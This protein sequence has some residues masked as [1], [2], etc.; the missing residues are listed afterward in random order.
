M[1]KIL[2]A[3]DFSTRS[4]RAIRRAVILARSI[5]ASITLVHVV[6][7]DQPARMLEAE[8][9]A[10]L[11]LLA[12]HAVSI[13]EIEGVECDPSVV[14]GD[15]FEGI[16]Q[17]AAALRPDLLV[18]G[19]HRRQALRDIFAGTTAERAI[20]ASRRPVVMANAV[21]AA[22][23]RHVLVALDLSA[24]SDAVLR[25]VGDLD[26]GKQA[27]LSVIHVFDAPGSGPM[28]RAVM[29]AT[30]REAYLAEEQARAARALDLSLGGSDV[31]PARRIL[32]CR[33]TSA[34]RHIHA[35]AR[36]ISADLIVVGTRGHGGL[37]TALLGSVAEEV[38]RT[39][40]LDVMA[41][42]PP[43]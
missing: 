7:D 3:T 27:K 20:R 14:L 28:S 4:D 30:Q 32:R 33:E 34:G 31:P 24:A 10:A 18:L 23:W 15:P 21:P 35:A 5:G 41:V 13:G 12:E 1:R 25:A 2:V 26:L 43:G 36:E 16:G 17:A 40:E 11:A 39:A 19:P 29:S 6:D 9:D 38:L 22:P 8:R 42:P 37:A